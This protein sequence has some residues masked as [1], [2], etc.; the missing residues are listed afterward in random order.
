MS[1]IAGG[2]CDGCH[3]VRYCSRACQRGD[4]RRH[5][6][7]CA[8]MKE[9]RLRIYWQEVPARVLVQHEQFSDD[10]MGLVTM[11]FPSMPMQGR[12][13]FMRRTSTVETQRLFVAAGMRVCDRASWAVFWQSSMG[14]W[15]LYGIY[16]LFVMG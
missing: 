8:E 12:F 15:A 11:R 4:W 7:L 1:I 10:I 14:L 2:Y 13:A 9:A 5:R 6:A 3:A 16:V